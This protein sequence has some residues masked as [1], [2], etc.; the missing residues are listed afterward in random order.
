MV[1]KVAGRVNDDGITGTADRVKALV[2]VRGGPNPALVFPLESPQRLV[3]LGQTVLV[4]DQ[5]VIENAAGF[6][7]ISTAALIEV[8]GLR[9]STGRIRATRI[10]DKAAQMGDNT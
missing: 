3:L 1:V 10:E 9:D 8:H 2:E 7:S 4:D 5:T 6:G